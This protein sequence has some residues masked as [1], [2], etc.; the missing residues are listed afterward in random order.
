MYGLEY[1]VEA[2]TRV[3]EL[4]EKLEEVEAENKKLRKK[5]KALDRIVGGLLE[6]IENQR[7]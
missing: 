3:K 2:N 7:R 6:V 5:N 1:D 4:S